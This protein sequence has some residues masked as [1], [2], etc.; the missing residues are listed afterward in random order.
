MQRISIT[1]L[2]DSVRSFLRKARREGIVVED[3]R[4]RAQCGIVPYR[5]ATAGARQR[6]WREI[7]KIQRKVGRTMKRKRT[8][9]EEFDRLLQEDE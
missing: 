2:N 6:A 7:K 1:D 9:E 4:G 5:E 3:E 8:T